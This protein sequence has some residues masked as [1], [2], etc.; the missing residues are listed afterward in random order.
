VYAGYIGFTADGGATDTYGD[1]LAA[2]VNQPGAAEGPGHRHQTYEPVPIG[3]AI[4]NADGADFNASPVWSIDQATWEEAGGRT[5]GTTTADQVTLGE[6][7]VGD[8]VVRIVGAVLPMPTEQYYHPFG[9]A[10]YAVTYTGYQVLNNALQWDR[11]ARPDL[12]VTDMTASNARA[13]S[14]E[15]VTLTATV[16]NAGDGG[17]APSQTEFRLSDGTVLGMAAT[18]AL[19]AGA[20][21]SVSVG[22]DTRGANGEYVITATADVLEAVAESAED[23]NLGELTVTVRG[24]KV[25]NSSFEQ[26]N[27]AGTGPDGWSGNSTSAGTTSWS[28]GGSDGARSATFTGTGGN[29]ALAGVPTWTSDP[30]AVTPGE[31]LTLAAK[32]QVSGASSAPSVGLAYL[33]PTG[34]LLQTVTLLTAPLTTDGFAALTQNVT[35]PQGVAQVRV[36]LAG[37]APTDVQTAGTVTFDEIG[38]FAQ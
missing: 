23:N 20:S 36:V 21:A 18:D 15:R 29:A 17:A 30:I 4:Q 3:F 26:P 8:G 33:G 6:L 11:P 34:T 5:A 35:I 38:L 1:P 37:F 14:G 19:A 7:A 31:V 22:W 24:N 27:S 25:R 10:N 9:L 13:P 28:A 16:T 32:V 12:Q 2:N